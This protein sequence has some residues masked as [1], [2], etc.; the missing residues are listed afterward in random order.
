MSS[1]VSSRL[2][3]SFFMSVSEKQFRRVRIRCFEN[4]SERRG[5]DALWGV[6]LRP[7]ES[8]W[9]RRKA[10]SSLWAVPD[11]LDGSEKELEVVL[12]CGNLFLNDWRMAAIRSA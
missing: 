3:F 2:K 11:V 8:A 10:N 6:Y 12:L 5:P 9:R 7:L 4:H 1:A